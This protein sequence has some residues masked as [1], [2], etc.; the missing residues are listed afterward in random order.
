MATAMKVAAA[1]RFNA[2]ESVREVR[3]LLLH[4]EYELEKLEGLK[5]IK[6]D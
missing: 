4:V 2:R 5:R 1:A 3:P 6:E